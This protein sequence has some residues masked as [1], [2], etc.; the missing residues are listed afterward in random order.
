MR[1]LTIRFFYSSSYIQFFF[2]FF[3][4]YSVFFS[5]LSL[6]ILENIPFLI[7][8]V[9]F[10]SQ[11]FFFFSYFD[12]IFFC[13]LGFPYIL[14][15]YF[16]IYLLLTDLNQSH[17]SFPI[18]IN[19]FCIF[20]PS[21]SFFLFSFS[22]FSLNIPVIKKKQKHLQCITIRRKFQYIRI[23]KVLPMHSYCKILSN[24][25]PL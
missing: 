9:H 20:I 11:F 10:F 21:L 5:F 14:T 12:F 15:P 2:L 3:T 16:F 1:F 22:L 8:R 13:L 24:A 4:I 23:M 17:L 25:F 7:I 19:R 6:T 18:L